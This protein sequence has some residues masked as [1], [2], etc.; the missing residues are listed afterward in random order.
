MVKRVIEIRRGLYLDPHPAMAHKTLFQ[1]VESVSA[2]LQAAIGRSTVMAKLRALLPSWMVPAAMPDHA[3]VRQVAVHV[4]Q[5]KA[6]R[7]QMT[8]HGMSS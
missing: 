6:A 2:Q 1:T 3:V 8:F 7:L 4:V 5:G